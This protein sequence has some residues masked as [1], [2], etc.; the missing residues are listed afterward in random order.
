MA[1]SF[2]MNFKPM[3]YSLQKE[4]YQ[5]RIDVIVVAIF[6]L[7]AGVV[8][9]MTALQVPEPILTDFYALDVWFGSDVPNVFGN[10]TSLRSEFGRN[11]KHPLFPIMVFPIVWILGKL[12]QL[13]M[14]TAARL[15][16]S[17]AA[18]L[19]L[20]LLYVLFR[21]MQLS[22]LEAIV[23]SLLGLVSAASL[24]WFAVPESFSFGSLT[25]LIGLV[26][27]FL[28][29]TYQFAPF[30]YVVVGVLTIGITITN[31]MVAIFATIVNF[32][33]KKAAIIT[34][35]TLVVTNIIWVFQRVVFVNTGF[36]F[37]PRTFFGEKEFIAELAKGSVLSAMSSFLYQTMI[38]PA[39]QFGEHALRPGWP[40]LDVD[41]L[42]PGSGGF[43][44]TVAAIAWTG[45]IALGLWG[46]F[47]TQKYKKFRIVLGLTILGQMAMHSIYGAELEET[48]IYSLHFAPLLLTVAAFSMLTPLRWVALALASGLVVSAG[49]NNVTLFNQVTGK[50][51]YYGTPQ[52]QVEAQM[53]LRPSDSWSRSEGHVVLASPGSDQE[54]KAYHE[55]GGSFSPAVGSFGVSIWLVDGNGHIQATSD[56]LPLEKIQQQ[57][58]AVAGQSIPGIATTT[59]FYQSAWS[60]LKPGNWQFSLQRVG[61]ANLKPVLVVRSVGPAG[62]AIH[63]LNWNGDRLLINDRWAVQNLPPG[64]KVY[65]GSETAA[66]WKR[67]TATGTQ[68]QDERGWGY[69]R[70][71][72]GSGDRWNLVVADTTPAT[73]TA[74]AIAEPASPLQLDLPNRQFVDSLNAQISHIR[75]GLVGNQTRPNDPVEHPL[76]RLRDGAYQLVALA[77][78]GQLETARKLSPYFAETD[79]LNGIEPEADIPA[80][81]IWALETVAEQ[82]NDP[83]YDQF[84]WQHVR[85]KAGLIMEMLSTNRPGYPV[86]KE[87]RFPFSEHPDFVRVDLFGGNVINSPNL[88]SLEKSASIM[89]YR[90][91]LD[92]AKLADRVKQPQEAQRWRAAADRLQAA[93]QKKF[94]PY[95]TKLDQTY[96]TGLWPSWLAASNQ[97]AFTEKLQKHWDASYDAQGA[98]LEQ[99][100]D[101]FFNVAEMHQWLLLGRSDRVWPTLQ[102]F[103]NHQASPGLYTWWGQASNPNGILTPQNLSQWARVRGW[104]DPPHI[105]PHYWSAAEM[106]LLQLD[107]LT[108]LDP[109]SRSPNLVIGAG[110]P[111]EWLNQPIR[112]NGLLVDGKVVNWAWDGQQMRVELQ[113]DR[114]PIKL[115]AAFPPN[116]PVQVVPLKLPEAPANKTE[117][118]VERV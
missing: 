21:L 62:G 35:V 108:Y 95:F 10:M 75:M 3:R 18:A 78:S 71:E 33:W 28:T 16:T 94:H 26:F 76:P 59:E 38:M 14:V 72:L 40:K 96:T 74:G 87:S 46:F 58:T 31:W 42:A 45:L 39:V 117:R 101:T 9:F 64:T 60:P 107:M 52:Q 116:T 103:W 5:H 47:T 84:I 92:A 61:N 115:G 22:R 34:L 118:T 2:I 32:R 104:I 43:W 20:G 41:A 51:M 66:D 12:F 100:E 97:Q 68:F 30:W 11:N 106:A 88:V 111:K 27:A 90:A 53:R 113:G 110:I 79:F 7:V 54:R 80:M 70:L 112:V 102:W 50:L 114:L 83:Q 19:W 98:P 15:A 25:I 56:T 57:L 23:F 105:T 4:L 17:L 49:I 91:L 13:D 67:Q 85:R 8:S 44:G 63:T 93:W 82:L 48:F 69:A 109:S 29:Q 73:A 81:G 86:A 37:Q 77:R 24:F 55:P 89:S 65:L 1:N 36:P 6:A 99:P